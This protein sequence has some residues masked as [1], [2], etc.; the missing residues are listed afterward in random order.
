MKKISPYDWLEANRY[1]EWL[2]EKVKKQKTKLNMIEHLCTRPI[3]HSFLVRFLEKWLLES[4]KEY[5]ERVEEP[6]EVE[7]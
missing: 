4:I 2:I 1:N 7:K 6:V 5:Y 3:A